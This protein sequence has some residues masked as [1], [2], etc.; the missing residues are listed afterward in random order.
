[1]TGGF[2]VDLIGIERHRRTV[3]SRYGVTSYLDIGTGPPAVFVH[4]LATSAY[5]WRNVIPRLADQRR[6]LAPDLPVHGRTPGSP[7]QDFSLNGLATF[8]EDFCTALELPPADLVANDTGGA[9]AR[10]SRRV[11]RSGWRR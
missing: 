6:C 4:G 11:A 7:D 10:S 8:V 3:T 5:L 2:D 1:L 9:I